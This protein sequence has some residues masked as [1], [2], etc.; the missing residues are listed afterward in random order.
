MQLNESAE[1]FE[2]LG[3]NVV[4]VSYDSHTKNSE[5]TNEQQIQYPILAD[6]NAATVK[7][8]GILNEE[9]EEGHPAFGIPHPGVL[10]VKPDATIGFKRA[11]PGYKDRPDL[12]ELLVAVADATNSFISV[13]KSPR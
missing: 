7:A 10:F 2:A 4:G 11:V 12:D 3:V 13:Q 5:F 1:T 9:Y 8:L 6:Q